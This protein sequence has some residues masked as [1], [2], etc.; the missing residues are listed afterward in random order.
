MLEYAPA[1]LDVAE[2]SMVQ[3][4]GLCCCYQ[5]TNLN[6]NL[7]LALC[8]CCSLIGLCER[9]QSGLGFVAL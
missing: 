9:L 6:I 3:R 4:M 5:T 8:A 2:Q 1:E 7:R